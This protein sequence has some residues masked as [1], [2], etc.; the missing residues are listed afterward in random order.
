MVVSC[1]AINSAA[2]LLRSTSDRHPRGLANSSDV[3]GRYYMRLLSSAWLALSLE[4]NPT[5]FQ[6]T[7]ALNEFYFGADDAEFPL[8]NIQMVGKSAMRSTSD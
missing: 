3:L 5:Q 6:K 8:G 1:G 2:L 7:L 4:P